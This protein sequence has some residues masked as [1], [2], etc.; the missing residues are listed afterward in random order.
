[1][2][3]NNNINSIKAKEELLTKINIEE[4]T[5]L[6]EL[7]VEML[8]D[9]ILID[10][11]EIEP[12]MQNEEFKKL[13]VTIRDLRELTHSLNNGELKKFVYSKGYVLSNLK[14]L[15]SNLR[16]LTWQTEQ[17]AKG[18]F[19][20]KVDFL[21]DF[22]SAFN[23]M[24]ECLKENSDKLK[25]LANIDVLTQIPNRSMLTEFL[26]STFQLAKRNSIEFGI[27]LFDID[28][29]KKVN[30]TYGHI[31]GDRVLVAISDML[32]R[33]F[34]TTDIFARYGGEEFMAVLTQVS[35]FDVKRI[36]ERALQHI[37]STPIVINDEITLRITVSAGASCYREED[38]AFEDII[39]RSDSA[40]YEA[41]N[42]GRDCMRIF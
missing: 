33:E 21:G 29:F 26:V 5:L 24:T 16:H 18:D 15:Q 7:I 2:R 1:M 39:K 20:Q 22:S 40:L 6:I 38:S 31:K 19:T 25:Y 36:G 14:A 9:S 28:F 41:K 10:E 30:D 12:L 13:Y 34:R 17:I 42:S 27:I 8:N 4:Y 11:E 35:E 32:K 37:R 23:E 3:Q